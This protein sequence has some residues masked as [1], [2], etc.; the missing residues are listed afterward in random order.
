VFRPSENRRTVNNR[1]RA[2]W[3][4]TPRAQQAVTPVGG[5]RVLDGIPGLLAWA[6]LILVS[7]GA[8]FAPWVVF[9]VAAVIG[10][11]MSLRVL[12]A[13]ITNIVGLRLIRRWN[14]KDWQ[15]E[16]GR[17]H[18]SD[19][20][21]WDVVKHVV[22]IPNYREELSVLQ[23][24][25]Q[26]L[27]DSPLAAEQVIVVLAMEAGDPHANAT[28]SALEHEF[29]G[30]FHRVI[31]T[32]HPRGLPGE[33]AGKSSNEA[34][35]AK[36]AKRILVDQEGYDVNHLVITI[37]DADTILHPRYL[38]SLN[39]L[40]AT[41]KNRY[42]TMWQSPI[43][44]HGNIW[45]TNP[46]LALAHAYSAS[47]ELAYMVGTWWQAFPMSSYSISMD[48]AARVGFW[49]TDV[50]AEDWHMFIKSYFGTHGTLKLRP[51]YLPF[52]AYAVAGANFVDACRN[53]YT[54][55][56]RHAWGVREVSYCAQ[57]M[58]QTGTPLHRGLRV[59]LRAAHDNLM[60]GT[61]WIV[62]TLGTQFPVLMHPNMVSEVG[63]PQFALIQASL[64][65]VITASLIFWYVDMQLRPPRVT[66]WR[67]S[68]VL[69][70]L[71][72]FPMTALLVLLLVALPVLEAQTRLMLGISLE[73]K[74][75]R[76]I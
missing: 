14:A 29:R 1:R 54:Q 47:W 30:K 9:T 48:L 65:A 68:E 17:H 8:V 40:F 45:K 61:G 41:D 59:F 26:R 7:V 3:R 35:A 70:T 39:Y 75:A 6:S 24:T 50:I 21:P 73:Y 16:Y 53:R 58:V 37:I 34:W 36:Y 72:S 28:A 63:A 42:S 44:Y 62:M 51:I 20:L 57:Q 71:F 56:V 18:S 11:Y 69:L 13:A 12:V 64:A 74:V 22:I 15:A 31:Y 52:S 46:I 19:S 43:R 5:R 49:D 10:G 66:K 27:A 32:L 25:L 60:A 4:S 23:D 67:L 55:T 38:E 33:V 76:K 2:M